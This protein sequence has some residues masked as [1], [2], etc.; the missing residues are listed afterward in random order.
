MNL[1]LFRLPIMKEL[2]KRKIKVYA[3]CPKGD[4]NKLLKSNGIE[5]VNYTIDRKSLNPFKERQ[6]IQNI[7]DAI[8]D[9]KLNLL[10]TF[11]A[12]PNIYGTFG[13]KKANIPIIVNLVEGLGS[14]YVRNNIKNIILR[15]FLEK[16]YK[17]SFTLSDKCIFVNY[18]DARYMVNKKIIDKNKV[19]VIKS[20][21]ID[22]KKFD[23]RNFDTNFLE[24]YKRSLNLNRKIIVLMVAR[25]IWDKGIKEYVEMAKILKKQYNNIEFLLIGDTDNGNPNCASEEFLK[26][27]PIVWLG[28]RKDIMELT[29]ICD[30]YVLPSFYKEGIPRTLL[31]AASMAKPI[32]TTDNVGCREV[33]IDGY[34]GF[35]VPVKDAV[36]LAEKVK[37]LI[38]DENLRERFGKNS[39]ELAV[40]EFDVKIVVE[41]YLDIYEKLLREKNV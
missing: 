14:L 40:K 39:R 16:L 24:K 23:M 9:L 21:G 17:K 7:Y 27:S 19:E 31:E 18:D 32:V 41:K 25:V 5:V 8:K 3:I 28:H 37:V 35:L 26:K 29:S 20:V 12:K 30:I 1:Y 4:Y 38:E 13:G 6:N 10:H 36:S 2:L 22:T 15:F 33:V 11:T 34:N